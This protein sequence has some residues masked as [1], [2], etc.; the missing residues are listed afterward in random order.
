MKSTKKRSISEKTKLLMKVRDLTRKSICKHVDKRQVTIRDKYKKLRNMV[1]SSIRAD[2]IQATKEKIKNSKDP[3]AMWKVAK[4][5]VNPKRSS[6]IT[7]IE[8]DSE[9]Q[10]EQNIANVFNSFFKSKVT[11]IEKAIP[12]FDNISPTDKCNVKMNASSKKFKL[13]TVSE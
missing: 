3:S 8:N 1:T 2:L 13:K 12:K 11:N 7:L 9:I 10:D 5:A 4:E 6:T